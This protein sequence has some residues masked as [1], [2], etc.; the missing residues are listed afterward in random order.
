MKP[1]E[2]IMNNDINAIGLNLQEHCRLMDEYHAGMREMKEINIK[3][4]R[5]QKYIRCLFDYLNN[6]KKPILKKKL[7]TELLN[8]RAGLTSMSHELYCTLKAAC[9]MA[10]GKQCEGAA[11]FSVI[12]L[13]YIFKYQGALKYECRESRL[14]DDQKA[15]V[16]DERLLD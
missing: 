16:I 7:M 1:I 6:F 11:D 4:N 9:L 14:T 3:R 10:K 15:V 5:V 12:K 13:D 2:M 8:F